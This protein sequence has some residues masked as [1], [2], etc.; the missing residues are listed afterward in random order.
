[1]HGGVE[2]GR[3]GLGRKMMQVDARVSRVA[4]YD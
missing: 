1:V 2:V 4:V 3:K